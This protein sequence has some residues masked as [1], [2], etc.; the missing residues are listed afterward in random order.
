MAPEGRA[1]DAQ[2]V[3]RFFRDLV[4]READYLPT[5]DRQELIAP[6]VALE[7]LV[8]SVGAKAVGFH[9]HALPSP[10]EVNLHL[11]AFQSHPDVH[12]R[13][14]Q[15]TAPTEPE[16]ALLQRAAGDALSRAAR[17][18]GG[19]Q[20]PDTGVPLPPGKK[21]TY[22]IHVQDAE[23]LCL[24][25]SSLEDSMTHDLGEIEQSSGHRGA[26]D[27]SNDC[28]IRITEALGAV[29]AEPRS[30]QPAA[31]SD[32]DVDARS[33]RRQQLV[34]CDRGPMRQQR[35]LPARQHGG[36]PSTLDRQIAATQ[37]IDAAMHAVQSPTGNASAHAGGTE[38]HST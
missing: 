16:E 36:H 34:K 7:G 3:L 21:F 28:S 19:A 13:L 25:A 18:Q 2:H 27:A 10:Y 38:P 23:H 12:L 15:I 35:S 9:D 5:G 32:R 11:L 24:V 6:A 17:V 8:R 22:G 4:P 30:R 26:R 1:R 14:R 33:T 37:C 29:Y 20:P 31:A